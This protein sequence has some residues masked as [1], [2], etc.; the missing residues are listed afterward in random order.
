MT[1]QHLDVDP[2]RANQVH[3]SKPIIRPSAVISPG[4]QSYRVGAYPKAREAG[5]ANRGAVVT[6]LSRDC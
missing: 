5:I 6:D 1:I 2:D 3:R 4:G